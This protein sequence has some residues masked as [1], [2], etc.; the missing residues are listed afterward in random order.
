ML[1]S[2]LTAEAHNRTDWAAILYVLER[3]AKRQ[4]RT[5]V[6]VAKSY[7]DAWRV[8]SP[9]PRALRMRVL[10]YTPSDPE[11]PYWQRARRLVD[12]WARGAVRDPCRGKAWHWAAPWV[13]P[14]GRMVRLHCGGTSNRFYGLAPRGRSGPIRQSLWA[15]V[16]IDL[17]HL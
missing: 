10:A 6:Q 3:R 17:D 8:R 16:G 4:V 14:R 5:M 2:A 12:R 11:Y 13:T 1:A 9:R 7:C 15:Q